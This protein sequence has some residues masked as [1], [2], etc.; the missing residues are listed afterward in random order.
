MK[1]LGRDFRGGKQKPK[2]QIMFNFPYISNQNS[3]NQN[4]NKMFVVID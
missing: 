3:K 1:I 4:G 2:A